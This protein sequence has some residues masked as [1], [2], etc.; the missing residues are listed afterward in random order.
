MPPTLKAGLLV[1]SLGEGI[2]PLTE[3][4][5]QLHA[6][7]LTVVLLVSY[8]RLFWN[9][10]DCSPPGPS[11]HGISQARIEEWAAISFSKGSS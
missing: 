2:H 4:L 8:V 1:Q 10:I 11:V 5:S 9:L 7:L 3:F 6:L